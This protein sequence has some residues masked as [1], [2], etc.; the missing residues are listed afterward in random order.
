[1]TSI[2]R[3]G[4]TVRIR[5]SY[6]NNVPVEVIGIWDSDD[7]RYIY[8]TPG[9]PLEMPILEDVEENIPTK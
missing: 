7:K 3:N 1:M 4:T 5:I 6:T 2:N 8:N 9:T